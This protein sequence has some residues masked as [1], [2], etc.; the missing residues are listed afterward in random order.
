MTEIE[1]AT[2]LGGPWTCA[3]PEVTGVAKAIVSAPALLPLNAEA[4][5]AA[6]ATEMAEWAAMLGCAEGPDRALKSDAGDV[7]RD[8]CAVPEAV[9]GKG[10]VNESEGSLGVVAGVV[11]GEMAG[12]WMPRSTGSEM[13]SEG[14]RVCS[15]SCVGRMYALC[16][17][18]AVALV[19]CFMFSKIDII[20]PETVWWYEGW[21][22]VAGAEE[23]FLVSGTVAAALG[24]PPSRSEGKGGTVLSVAVEV[25]EGT[26]WDW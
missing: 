15:A 14:G 8:A 24:V 5:D 16:T 13:A 1:G 19:V 22:S 10:A 11:P 21:N 3:S 26:G 17:S 18:G 25:E 23:Y 6:D 4:V 12:S 2:E 9:A 20:T 7:E